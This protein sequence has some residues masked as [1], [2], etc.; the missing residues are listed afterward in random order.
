[1]SEGGN[2]SIDFNAS[3]RELNCDIKFSGP[4][5]SDGHQLPVLCYAAI[6][7]AAFLFVFFKVTETKGK[8]L[9]EIEQDLRDRH[10]GITGTDTQPVER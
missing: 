4:H 8:S 6:G 7:I 1:M 5:G 2:R 3:C 10:G 9:E